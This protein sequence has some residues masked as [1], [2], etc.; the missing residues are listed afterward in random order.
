MSATGS[1]KSASSDNL[2]APSETS[3]PI[4]A[5]GP[6]QV[7]VDLLMGEEYDVDLDIAKRMG[8]VQGKPL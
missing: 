6:E 4:W 7:K 8:I 2:K 1:K 5:T 3:T